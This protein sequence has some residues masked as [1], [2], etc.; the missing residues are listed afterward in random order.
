MK[1]LDLEC[2]YD[3]RLSLTAKG[4]FFSLPSIKVGEIIYTKLANKIDSAEDVK[5][6]CDEL[7]AFGYIGRVQH[8]E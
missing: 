2:I 1:K 4:V 7:T 5:K 3:S 6:A 8:G